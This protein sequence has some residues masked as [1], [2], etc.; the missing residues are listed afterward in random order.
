MEFREVDS[1]K[2]KTAKKH[3]SKLRAVVFAVSFLIIIALAVWIF[4][5]TVLFPIE[6]IKVTDSGIYSSQEIIDTAKLS[7]G[8]KLYS[9]SQKNTEELLTTKL[10]YIKTV[11]FKRSI[12]PDVTLEII[13]TET[14]DVFCYEYKNM[15]YSADKDNKVLS[16]FTVQPQGTTLVKTNKKLDI[17]LGNTIVMDENDFNNLTTIHSK[18]TNNNL[19]VNY[20]DIT[21]EN[22]IKILIDNRFIVELGTVSNLDGKIAHLN[23]MIEKIFEKNGKDTMGC[24]DL[25]A[26]T[27]KNQRAYYEPSNIF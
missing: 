20:I 11:E 4:S 17:V 24:I 27:N 12:L 22:D 18:L 14:S 21:N 8:D 26:W 2:E 3:R 5:Y 19:T 16:K 25:S 7:T 10:P 9:I 13:V 23:G 1:R 15:Y 6:H